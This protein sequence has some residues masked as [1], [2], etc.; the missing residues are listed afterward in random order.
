MNMYKFYVKLKGD[1]ENISL[2]FPDF[3]DIPEYK[4]KRKNDLDDLVCMAEVL[5]EVHLERLI[6]SNQEIP[7]PSKPEDIPLSVDASLHLVEV[8]I[9]DEESKKERERALY[10]EF[11]PEK[12][13]K[14]VMS[15]KKE[16]IYIENH[17]AALLDFL[18]DARASGKCTHTQKDNLFEIDAEKYIIK[19]L[20][21]HSGDACFF[22]INKKTGYKG[23]IGRR[24]FT[25]N[26]QN[27]LG[28]FI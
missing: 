10:S 15:L 1:I 27:Y 9:E 20:I 26:V 8:K 19:I 17:K 14:F 21:I 23:N 7:S 18:M 3:P 13:M 22:T 6:S 25:Y 12:D 2:S 16:P 28:N 11:I 24:M 4:P 5:L